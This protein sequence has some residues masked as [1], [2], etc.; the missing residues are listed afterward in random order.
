[1]RSRPAFLVAAAL[2]AA[3]CAPAAEAPTDPDALPLKGT[4]P[5]SPLE[6]V[7]FVLP[8]T[9]G[10]AY[11]FR[12]E[13]EGRIALL[14]FGYTYCPD[15]CPI[16]MA[17]LASAL[18]DL[19]EEVRGRVVTVFATV[20]PAR[21]TPERLGSWLAAFDSSFVGVRGTL[22]EV[23]EAL[24]FYGYHAPETSGEEVGYTVGHPALIY[25]FTPDGLGRAMYGPETPKATWVHDLTLMAG[26]DWSGTTAPAAPASADGALALEAGG[27]QILD[28]VVP[29]PPTATTTAFY[30]T[31][32]NVGPE[33]DT[34]LGISSA[35]AEHASLHDMV[36][37]G[38]VM[39]MAPL[40]GGITLEPGATV[41]LEPGARHGM[42]EGLGEL[43]EAGGTV[44]VVLRFARAGEV[45]VP[46]RV[47]RY[48]DVGRRGPR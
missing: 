44:T 43:P 7:D 42:L 29:R 5:F 8:D 25:A 9:R 36:L 21:D 1:M 20:D 27:I 30:F 17:T 4:A 46:A 47:V 34:L 22:E 3:A 32:R 28:P 11:D 48:E 14:F 26:H 12:R 19:P 18:R 38:N 24:A 10:D 2:L 13:T 33:A 39:R 16:H 45:A 6:K 41:R 15:I 37:E 40:E 23:T 31:L 35:V